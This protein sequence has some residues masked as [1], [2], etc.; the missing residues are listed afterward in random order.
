MARLS[1]AKQAEQSARALE[2]LQS[3][4]EIT[5]PARLRALREAQGLAQAPL[6]ETLG[7]SD[8]S[9]AVWEMG[10][11][12]KGVCAHKIEAWS[13]KAARELGVPRRVIFASEWLTEEERG[14][15]AALA[16]GASAA[17]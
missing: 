10:R 16:K 9:V 5:P 3:T 6:A 4:A 1:K 13:L 7:V 14:E 2:L 8:G 11:A 15:V 12:P 17:P